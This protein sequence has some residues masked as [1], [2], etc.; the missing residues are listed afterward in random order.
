[1]WQIWT[2]T[3]C[4]PRVARLPA[5]SVS[6]SVVKWFW[7]FRAPVFWCHAGGLHIFRGHF[8]CTAVFVEGTWLLARLPCSKQ[9]GRV[10][11]GPTVVR[12]EMQLF[13]GNVHF[14]CGVFAV[15]GRRF[16]ALPFFWLWSH[17]DLVRTTF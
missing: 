11:L 7:V 1:M 4:L 12:V 13:S 14:F 6:V 9:R 3:L 2:L 8:I 5:V 15:F 10:A 16:V 17:C